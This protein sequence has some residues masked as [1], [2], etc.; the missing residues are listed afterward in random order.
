[1]RINFEQKFNKPADFLIRRCGYG[2][3]RDRRTGGFSYA[4]RLGG[5]LYPRFHLYVNSEDPLILNLHLDQKQ[6]SYAGQTA[7][8]GDYDS[9]L[10][11]KEVQRI[12]ETILSQAVSGETDFYAGTEDYTEE[13]KGFF[14]RLFGRK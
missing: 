10:V 7:H 3:I 14:S 6:A 1:M 11:K 2:Q 5:G 12:F 9:D 13:P 4:R 8:S